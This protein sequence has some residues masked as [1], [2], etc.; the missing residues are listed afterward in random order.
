MTFSVHLEHPVPDYE[1]W[2]AAFDA[3]PLDRA[4]SGVLAYRVLR[5]VEDHGRVAVDLE[6]ADRESA[7]RFSASLRRLWSTSGAMAIMRDPV[8]R[9]E[10]VAEARRLAG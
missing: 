6:F 7:E 3:D 8:V 1:A 10:D 9:I 5:P 4:G 2:K